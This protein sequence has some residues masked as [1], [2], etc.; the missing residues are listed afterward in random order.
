M[1]ELK[2]R[3]GCI[4][5]TGYHCGNYPYSSVC[6][7]CKHYSPETVNVVPR[8]DK[9]SMKEIELP[10]F[11]Y[12]EKTDTLKKLGLDYKLSDCEIRYMTFYNI[13]AVSPYL[14]EDKEY[15]SIHSNGSEFICSL[16]YLKVK[17]KMC[18]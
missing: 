1:V 14:D 7:R 16:S 9:N 8:Y 15:C 2:S 11:H 5:P 4:A 3:Y 18:K 10:I 12:T 6:K 13:N 17:E